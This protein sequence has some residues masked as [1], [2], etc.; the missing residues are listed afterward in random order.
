ML[1]KN[2]DRCVCTFGPEGMEFIHP[3]LKKYADGARMKAKP[4]V[5]VTSADVRHAEKA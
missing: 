1:A 5:E 3:G 4:E 2:N